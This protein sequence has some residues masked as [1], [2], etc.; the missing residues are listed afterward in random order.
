MRWV[1]PKKEFPHF[2]IARRRCAK[3]LELMEEY[4]Y[5]QIWPGEKY[6]FH[7]KNIYL[8]YLCMLNFHNNLHLI[9]LYFQKNLQHDSCSDS[10]ISFRIVNIYSKCR[11]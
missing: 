10:A 8:R 2:E 6:L 11:V 9:V 1:Y 5:L 4:A 7:L 3:K